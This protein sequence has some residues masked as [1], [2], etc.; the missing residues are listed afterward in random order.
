MSDASGQ[1]YIQT[2]R[3]E[4][5][6]YRVE[7]RDGSPAEHYMTD[8][9]DMRTAHALITSWAFDVPASALPVEWAPMQMND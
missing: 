1:T 5:G 8:A 4:D 6:S 7:R 9:P 2:I 3:N